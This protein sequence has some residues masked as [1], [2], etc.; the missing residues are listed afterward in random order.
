M[1]LLALACV[2]SDD[3][4]AEPV[5]S[6]RAPPLAQ[7]HTVN[8]D[9]GAAIVLN[10]RQADGPPVIIVHGISSNHHCWDLTP[11]R[12]LAVYLQE[13]GFDA[14]LL[15]LRCH[16]DATL[17]A[18][19]KRQW[20]GWSIDHYGRHDVPAAVDYVLQKTGSERVGYVGHSLGGMVGAIYAGTHPGANDKLSALIAV[21]SPMDFSDPDPVV[22]SA[23]TTAGF[24]WIPVIPSDLG[25]KVAALLDG[26]THTAVDRWAQDLLF[27]D[28]QQDLIGEMYS[29]VASPLTRGELKQLSLVTREGVF[30]DAEGEV[31]YVEAL[32]N[33]QVPT[34]VISGRG[35][36]IAPVD[37][38]YAYYASTGAEQKR[39]VVAGKAQGFAADYG[40]LD[41]PLGDHA[42][43]EIYPLI[44]DWLI[45]PTDAP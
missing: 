36:Q 41:L 33:V 16:G 5:A 29:R 10:R 6:E 44:R 17:D 20:A 23:L 30:V 39:F 13:Q 32:T 22:W 38:V 34:L 1:I 25:G 14:W 21:G 27:T 35:D 9:D 15:D 8:T 31:D 24:T 12:S 45:A 18:T 4:V 40:H 43:E 42:R 28:I 2:V 7:K 37:R 26:E 19:G 11:E 3:E